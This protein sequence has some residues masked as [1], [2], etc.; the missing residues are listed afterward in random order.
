T[1][2]YYPKAPIRQGAER[3]S[4]LAHPSDTTA[5]R[6][7][8]RQKRLLWCVIPK[9]D[10]IRV[11]GCTA[12]KTSHCLNKLIARHIRECARHSRRVDGKA[13][14]LKIQPD[15]PHVKRRCDLIVDDVVDLE[16]AGIRVAQHHVGRAGSVKWAETCYLK[17]QANRAQVGG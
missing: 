15:R 10:A 5:S 11:V 12:A 16:L 3:V 13:A 9:K 7:R 14:E 1:L 2:R 17:I 6:L 8:R 4:A